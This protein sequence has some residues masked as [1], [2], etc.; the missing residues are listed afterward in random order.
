MLVPSTDDVPA[1]EAVP[2]TRYFSRWVTVVCT[3]LCLA[4]VTVYAAPWHGSPLDSLD[5]PDDALE[6]LVSRD[7]DT[8]EALRLSPRWEQW[9][10]GV[11]VGSDDPVPEAL[12]WYDELV[13]SV[14]SP[15]AEVYQALLRAETGELPPRGAAGSEW[16][17][18]AYSDEPVDPAAGRDMIENIRATLPANWFT[19]TLVA[20]I[21]DRIGDGGVAARAHA[22]IVTRG[23]SLLVRWRVLSGVEIFLVLAALVLLLRARRRGHLPSFGPASL[24]PTWGLANGYALVVR[25]VLGLLGVTLLVV[26]ALPEWRITVRLVS[27]LA[28]V[29]VL[30]WTGAYLRARGDSFAQTFG[31]VLPLG[32]IG[33]VLVLALVLV[34]VGGAAEAGVG[35]LVGALGV[36][37]HWAD[38]LPEDL[39]WDPPWLVLVG[40]LDTVVWTPFIE[41]LTFRGLLYGTLRTVTGAPLAAIAS[42]CLFAAAHGYGLSGFL[43]VF[44]SGIIWAL[45][46]ERSRSLVPGILAHAV[47]NLSVTI[48]YL[49]MLRM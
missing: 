44:L 31:F 41:E 45:A 36:D 43:S 17:I 37:S 48:T 7:L 10:Y 35:T 5:R 9:L 34:G 26:M 29:P 33:R 47:N 40:V 39:L 3:I 20:R 27:F 21:A 8:R 15:P 6:R 28:G 13:E 11:L 1:S 4:V 16:V 14:E 38:G 22:D 24:P 49:V 25:S 18:V 46:Y 2:P 12:G 42:G 30:L 32:S 19:D 23:R